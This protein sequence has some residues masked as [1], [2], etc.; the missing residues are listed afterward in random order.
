MPTVV[1]PQITEGYEN[2]TITEKITVEACQ[3]SSLQFNKYIE[4]WRSNQKKKI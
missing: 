4:V 2:Y 3:M 1:Q